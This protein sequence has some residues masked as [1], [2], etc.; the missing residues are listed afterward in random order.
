[1]NTNNQLLATSAMPIYLSMPRGINVG[2]HKKIKMD[3]LRT[4][5]EAIGLETVKTYIQSGNIVFKSKSTSSA[6]VSKQIEAAI[7]EDFGH[8]VTVITRTAD[9]LARA[10][11][12]NPFLN[13]PGVDPE[14]LHLMFLSDAPNPAAVEK[15][16][17]FATPPEAL[18]NI[19][20]EI[21]F[22]LPNG[23]AN[24]LWMKKPIDRI[25]GVVTTTRNLRTVNTLH[26][27]CADSA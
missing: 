16:Q 15:L 11:K 21:Y 22:Y 8:S 6:A 27:M 7:F 9:E 10:I 13:Q 1:M 4:A 3:Q 26:Q 19:G 17:S 25:L 18:R 20:K 14:K 12:N 23:V 2:G 24:S 5:L